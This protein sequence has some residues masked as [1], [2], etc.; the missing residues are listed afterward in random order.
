MHTQLGVHI[1]SFFLILDKIVKSGVTP[2]RSVS[3][4]LYARLVRLVHEPS[5]AECCNHALIPIC[6]TPTMKILKIM[7]LIS[8]KW[9]ILQKP[10]LARCQS[11]VH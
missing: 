1:P 3:Y 10:A 7:G 8:H 11:L 5:Q 9:E 2:H 6:N 4:E